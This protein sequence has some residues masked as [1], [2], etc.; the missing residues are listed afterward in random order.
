[1]PTYDFWLKIK[2]FQPFRPPGSVTDFFYF[3][4]I[5]FSAK[6]LFASSAAL[7][8]SNQNSQYR[9]SI[10]TWV[11]FKSSQY[12]SPLRRR[13]LY[14][15]ELWRH[16]RFLA[17]LQAFS[18][19]HKFRIGLRLFYC[20]MPSGWIASSF[21]NETLPFG[22]KLF[23]N[24]PCSIRTTESFFLNSKVAVKLLP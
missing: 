8:F 11:L 23:S 6:M 21:D 3:Q 17:Y 10:D 13:V 4:P 1:M 16:A 12:R 19:L 5:F 14:P 2:V 20:L 7:G 9:I 15:A 24:A 22:G 18:A